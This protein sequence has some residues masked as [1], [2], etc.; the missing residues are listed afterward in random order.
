[1]KTL[2]ISFLSSIIKIFKVLLQTDSDLSEKVKNEIETGK[3]DADK[4]HLDT[5]KFKSKT[6]EINCKNAIKTINRSF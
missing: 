5:Y 4:L 1:M 3:V 6:M 2:K